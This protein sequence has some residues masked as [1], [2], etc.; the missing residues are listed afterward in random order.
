[1][2][3]LP[4]GTIAGEVGDVPDVKAA[5]PRSLV[6]L[7]LRLLYAICLVN[8]GRTSPAGLVACPHGLAIGRSGQEM[9]A[10]AN[11]VDELARG[12]VRQI[13]DTPYFTASAAVTRVLKLLCIGIRYFMGLR[14][15]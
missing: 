1:M 8:A 14:G 3:L 6:E 4:D 13:I 5:S 10:H 7:L 9:Y 11:L 15:G 12:L 2:R